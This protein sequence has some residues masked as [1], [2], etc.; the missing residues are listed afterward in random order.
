M[1]DSRQTSSCNLYLNNDLIIRDARDTNQ[2]CKPNRPTSTAILFFV[3][4]MLA[5]F[6][7]FRH[8]SCS[9]QSYN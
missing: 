5:Y 9:I 7:V 4:V 2:C 6:V 8:T 1:I 3:F